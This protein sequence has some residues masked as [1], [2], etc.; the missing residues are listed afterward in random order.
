MLQLRKK[1]QHQSQKLH[2]VSTKVFEEG[3]SFPDI[4]GKYIVGKKYPSP[5]IAFGICRIQKE[6]ERKHSTLDK[7]G[8]PKDDSG[9]RPLMNMMQGETIRT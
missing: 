6:G 9:T 1:S 3:M 5:W 4:L 8:L 2:T 7:S